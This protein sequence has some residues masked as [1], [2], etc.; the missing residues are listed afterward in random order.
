MIF[1]SLGDF[2]ALA[3][4]PATLVIPIGG[5]IASLNCFIE[6]IFKYHVVLDLDVGETC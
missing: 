6:E 4:A 2:I 3:F 1:G 5:F